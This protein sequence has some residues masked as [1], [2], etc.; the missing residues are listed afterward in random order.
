MTKAVTEILAQLNSLTQSERAELAYAFL[1]SLEPEEPGA[2]EA[3]DVELDQRVARILEGQ[4]KG[5]PAEQ[6]FADWRREQP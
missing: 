3:W 6:V 1:C 5:K 2:A 4:T